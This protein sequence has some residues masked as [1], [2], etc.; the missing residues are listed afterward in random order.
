METM[1][2]G[3]KYAQASKGVV[4]ADGHS[5]SRRFGWRDIKSLLVESLSDW[6]KHNAPRLGA[7]LAF[8]SLLSLAPLLLV[9]VSIV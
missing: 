5:T 7:S 1:N 8:Y 2:S 4:T 3:E 9:L 6:N